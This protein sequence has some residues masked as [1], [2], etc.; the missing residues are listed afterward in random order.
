ML[1]ATSPVS[2]FPQSTAQSANVLDV[3]ATVSVL[4][5]FEKNGTQLTPRLKWAVKAALST[6]IP[7]QV[8]NSHLTQHF[9][10]AA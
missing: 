8:G 10:S 5:A 6:R 2:A 1:K 4:W 9:N 3:Q 7:F